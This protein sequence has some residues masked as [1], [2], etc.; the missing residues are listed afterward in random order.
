MAGF[1]SIGAKHYIRDMAK[2]TKKEL[3]NRIAELEEMVI[4]LEDQLR[5]AYEKE[6]ARLRGELSRSGKAKAT[7]LKKVGD[8]QRETEAVKST[9]I[10][11][12]CKRRRIEDSEPTQ[13]PANP[14]LN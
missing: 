4:E 6:E 10:C 2:T 9:L 8:A 11:T 7:I 13:G 1:V 12:E 5:T 3:E 14:H